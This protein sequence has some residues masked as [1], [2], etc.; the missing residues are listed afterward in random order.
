[1]GQ[2][3][4]GVKL[5]GCETVEIGLAQE[6]VGI[7]INTAREAI[8][9]AAVALAIIG[10]DGELGPCLG[11]VGKGRRNIKAIITR[12]ILSAFGVLPQGGETVCPVAVFGNRS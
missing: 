5:L 10:Q 2:Q 11:L 9:K 4:T 12:I 7:N 1:M 6:S 8:T 3:V